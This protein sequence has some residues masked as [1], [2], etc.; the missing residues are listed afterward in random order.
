VCL[1]LSLNGSKISRRWWDFGKSK[2]K[3]VWA[4]QGGPPSLNCGNE[5][6]FCNTAGKLWPKRLPSPSTIG[7]GHRYRGDTAGRT[8]FSKKIYFI[9]DRTGL[10]SL[11]QLSHWARRLSPPLLGGSLACRVWRV[12]SVAS[13]PEGHLESTARFV[14]TQSRGWDY[15]YIT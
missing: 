14:A 13:S 8:H 1:G 12:C 2:S 11:P 9:L 7:P 6:V 5:S 10:V 3:S 15:M 4:I